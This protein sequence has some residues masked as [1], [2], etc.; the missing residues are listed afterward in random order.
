MSMPVVYVVAS[1]YIHASIAAAVLAE[2]PTSSFPE[3]PH[4]VGD[5]AQAL[6][7]EFALLVAIKHCLAGNSAAM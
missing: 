4:T 6:N 7:I 1:M 2:C 5:L 3:K